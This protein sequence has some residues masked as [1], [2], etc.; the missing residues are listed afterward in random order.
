MLDNDPV[1]PCQM[2]RE[3]EEYALPGQRLAWGMIKWARIDIE[4]YCLRRDHDPIGQKRRH[5][6]FQSAWN[7][8]FSE[9]RDYHFSFLN[10]CDHTKSDARMM[11]LEFRQMR[12]VEKQ[13]TDASLS[14]VAGLRALH[15]GGSLT[16]LPGEAERAV[17]EQQRKRAERA[18]AHQEETE[19]LLA[20]M[21]QPPEERKVLTFDEWQATLDLITVSFIGG[22]FHGETQER[23]IVLAGN[24]EQQLNYLF[25]PYVLKEQHP[26]TVFVM[27]HREQEE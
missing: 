21:A 7:W 26:G 6:Y 4:R 11:R 27:G 12:G 18:R 5:F 13:R 16:V 22:P 24:V 9:D 1:L 3:C 8:V 10:C 15:K 19:K 14:E 2:E 25:Q 17:Q 23:R 20:R